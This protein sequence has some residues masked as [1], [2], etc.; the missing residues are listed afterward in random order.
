MRLLNYVIKYGW[1]PLV[2]AC[3]VA[4]LPLALSADVV[5]GIPS[6]MYWYIGLYGTFALFLMMVASGLY[7]W[8]KSKPHHRS[9][10]AH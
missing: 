8:L 6:W 4:F 9:E 3:L 2:P 10:H 1:I 5:G 7:L